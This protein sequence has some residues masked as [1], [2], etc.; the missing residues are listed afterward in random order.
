MLLLLLLRH[1]LAGWPVGFRWRLSYPSVRK[2]V[3]FEFRDPVLPVRGAPNSLG[4]RTH[5]SVTVTGPEIRDAHSHMTS[6]CDTCS[7]LLASAHGRRRRN[8]SFFIRFLLGGTC[9]LL[10]TSYDGYYFSNRIMFINF[11]PR[12]DSPESGPPVAQKSQEVRCCSKVIAIV[13]GHYLC[14]KYAK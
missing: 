9:G 7:H 6:S 11:Q 8:W 10:R 1:P 14:S 13:N 4:G 12:S 3:T 5:D 2:V